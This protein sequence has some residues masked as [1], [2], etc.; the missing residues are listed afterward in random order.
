MRGR[1]SNLQFNNSILQDTILC[2]VYDTTKNVNWANVADSICIKVKRD[3]NKSGFPILIT[4][5]SNPNRNTW[6][7]KWGKTIALKICN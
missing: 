6:E 5:T 2:L 1:A 3:C 7:T 4:N